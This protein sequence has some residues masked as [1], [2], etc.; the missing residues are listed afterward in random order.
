MLFFVGHKDRDEH[1]VLMNNLST[2]ANN[3]IIFLYRCL[4]IWDINSKCHFSQ[5]QIEIHF[6]PEGFKKE[7]TKHWEK[8]KIIYSKI[9]NMFYLIA[10]VLRIFILFLAIQKLSNDLYTKVM[11]LVL[12]G[13]VKI[14]TIINILEK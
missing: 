5:E 2:K 14:R 11:L 6:V 3:K 8:E 4:L 7:G 12:L 1:L 9:L 10:P 13:I